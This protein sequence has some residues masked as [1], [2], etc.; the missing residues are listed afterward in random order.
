MTSGIKKQ[1]QYM[2][3]QQIPCQDYPNTCYQIGGSNNNQNQLGY[4]PPPSYGAPMHQ[5]GGNG[6]HNPAYQTTPGLFGHSRPPSPMYPHSN[7]S[8]NQQQIFVTIK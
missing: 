2:H 1:Q 7:V 3:Q 8:D 5:S 6:A 4:P